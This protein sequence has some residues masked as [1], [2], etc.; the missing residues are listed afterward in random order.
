MEL[1]NSSSESRTVIFRTA[2]S[3]K[4]TDKY[5]SYFFQKLEFS[6][7]IIKLFFSHVLIERKVY[8][9]ILYAGINKLH[10]NFRLHILRTKLHI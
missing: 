10:N 4:C 5:F 9:T 3:N 7:C 2:F 6:L 1:I 8:R